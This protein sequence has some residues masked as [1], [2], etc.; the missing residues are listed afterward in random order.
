MCADAGFKTKGEIEPVTRIRIDS[1]AK[2]KIL[3]FIMMK[4]SVRLFILT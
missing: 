2:I 3:F 4:L 1:A